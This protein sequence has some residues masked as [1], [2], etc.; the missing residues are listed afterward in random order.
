MT[1]LLLRKLLLASTRRSQQQQWRAKS[2]SGSTRSP[3]SVRR[4]LVQMQHSRRSRRRMR[5]RVHKGWMSEALSIPPML[6]LGEQRRPRGGS[7]SCHPMREAVREGQRDAPA[8]V[9][10]LEGACG[11]G[12]YM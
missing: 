5:L 2:R 12:T 1:L 9:P 6:P 10:R 4:G 7:R 8:A 11:Y 3:P